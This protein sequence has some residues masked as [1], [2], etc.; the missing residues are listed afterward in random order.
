MAIIILMAIIKTIAMIDAIA[1]YRLQSW[2]SPAF[3]TGAFSYSHGL[4]TAVGNGVVNN[5]EELTW[6]L[7]ALL[8]QGPGWNDGVFLAESWRLT[9]MNMDLSELND[10]VCAGASSRERHLETTAQGKAFLQAAASWNENETLLQ[11]L[12]LPLGVGMIAAS[13][14]IALESVLVAYLQ[15]Y[16]SNQIQAALRLMRL[17]QQQGVI[18]LSELEGDVIATAKKCALSSIDD[19]GSISLMAD[20]CAAQHEVQ[21]SRLFRS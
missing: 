19:L 12:A 14:S 11:N 17:G 6:W 5:A 18:I 2:L 21:Q 4:E 9:T 15:A 7:G 13:H 3:P 16:I 20:I 1:L 8:S 10:L